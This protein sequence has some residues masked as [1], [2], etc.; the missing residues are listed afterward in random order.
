MN[1]SVGLWRAVHLAAAA[2]LM[3]TIPA[4]A[5]IPG[6]SY[7]EEAVA[8]FQTITSEQLATMLDEKDFAFFNVHIPYE[9]EIA[10]T[11][12]LIPFDQ[13]EENL[14]QLP[15]DRSAPIVLYCRSGRMSE[16][17]ANELATRG[18]TNVSHLGGGM[19]AWVEAGGYLLHK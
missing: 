6:V 12:A 7:A 2:A 14:D 11:D 16:I 13:I 3:A 9:G 19:N 1:G 18:Y 5:A 4:V 17:A 8:A 15:S 10:G